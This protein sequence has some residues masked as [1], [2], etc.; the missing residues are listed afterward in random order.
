VTTVPR[1]AAAAVRPYHFPTIERDRLPNGVRLVVAPMHRLPLVTVLALVDAGACADPVGAEGVAALTA[2]VLA[3]GS[4]TLDGVALAERFE[5]LGTSFDA[6]ADWDASIARITVLP[7]RLDA[8]CALF[9]EVVRAPAFPAPDVARR[10]DERLADLAQRLAEP[11]GLADQRFVGALYAPSSRFARPA[12]GNAAAVAKLGD[13]EV[14]TFHAARYGPATTTLVIVG[15]CTADRAR[16]LALATFGDWRT[17]AAPA[18]AAQATPAHVGRRTRIVRKAG[19]P[20]SELRVGHIGVPRAHPDHLA[21]VV[22]NAILGGLFSSRLNL[23]L[24]ERNAFTYGASSGFDWRRAAGPF[25]ASSAVKSEVTAR[26]VEEILREI[27]GMR[28]APPSRQEVSLATEY[29]AGVFPI[30]FESTAAVAGALASATTHALP[31]DWFETYRD[32]V[33]RVDASSV[34]AAAKA[35]L[36]P[37]RLLVLAVGDPDEIEAPLAALAHGPLTVRD[38]HE[39][40]ES[41]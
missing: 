20:Q 27:E 28:A 39:D 10:R 6:Y 14:R 35:H 23:N 26:A 16:T 3:E 2:R 18:T 19:A 5:A 34:H 38:P 29:L 13:A 33:Q 11:R 1:P 21:I 25:V 8:A 36:H 12:G 37:D 4:G 30:R 32:Q 17:P 31:D 15:D 7:G 41:G 24:R 9:A 22:M 40:E